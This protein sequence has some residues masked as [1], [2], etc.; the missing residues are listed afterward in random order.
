MNLFN[1]KI[2]DFIF[3][4]L[5]ILNCCKDKNEQYTVK[6][7]DHEFG[8]KLSLKLSKKPIKTYSEI[9]LNEDISS[10]DLTKWKIFNST[11]GVAYFIIKNYYNNKLCYNL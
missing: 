1:I 11:K 8:L 9:Y 6:S 10:I 2:T 4:L 7:E 5:L 3:K